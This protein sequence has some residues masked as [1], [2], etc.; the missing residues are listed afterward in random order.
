[1][2]AWSKKNQ[3]TRVQAGHDTK[4]V[5]QGVVPS[6]AALHSQVEK[7]TSLLPVQ[8][9]QL[10]CACPG[11]EQFY[12]IAKNVQGGTIFTQQQLAAQP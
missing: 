7:P 3:S 9:L 6:Q 11:A 2:Q 8:T 1:M 5:V 4:P 12:Q 10:L